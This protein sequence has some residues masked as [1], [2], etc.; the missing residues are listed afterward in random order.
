MDGGG[1][2]ERKRE[3]EPNH[4]QFTPAHMGAHDQLPPSAGVSVSL[5]TEEAGVGSDESVSCA[6]FTSGG[7]GSGTVLSCKVKQGSRTLGCA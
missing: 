5:S 2:R 6:S 4:A 3:Q 7:K 1:Q